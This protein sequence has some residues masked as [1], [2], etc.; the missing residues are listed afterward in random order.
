MKSSSV[1]EN[2]LLT[3]TPNMRPRRGPEPKRVPIYR[4][5]VEVPSEEEL[6]V[7][8]FELPIGSVKKPN[9]KLPH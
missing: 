5:P 7:E 8:D 1:N 2:R 3:P 4:R 9:S 6:E